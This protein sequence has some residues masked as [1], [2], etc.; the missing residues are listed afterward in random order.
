M[1]LPVPVLGF[2]PSTTMSEVCSDASIEP[3]LQLVEGKPLQ[4]ATE[5]DAHLMSLPGTFGAIVYI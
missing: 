1:S 4:V 3:A 5:D 2:H